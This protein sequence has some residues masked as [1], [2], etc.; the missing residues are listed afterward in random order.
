MGAEASEG[1]SGGTSAD[2]ERREPSAD[3]VLWDRL[4]ALTTRVESALERTLQRRFSFGLS[5]FTAIRALVEAPTGDL[6][7]Q[8]LTDI[9]G[10]NQSSV[11]RLVARL[12]QAGLAARRLCET[13]RRGVY[14]GVTPLGRQVFQAAAEIYEATL[15][16]TFDRIEHDADLG[17]LLLA[18]RT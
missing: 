12:E 9:V 11:S 1:G 4:R 17:P 5:E 14:T 16:S 6:R 8:D 15:A 18:L 2:A 7:M 13:D 3:R 10:L